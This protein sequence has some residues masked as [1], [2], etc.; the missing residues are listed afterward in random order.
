MG[1]FAQYRKRG[2]GN[3]GFIAAAPALAS[4]TFVNG[5]GHATI[6]PTNPGISGVVDVVAIVYHLA[7]PNIID[8]QFVC[9]FGSGTSGG[10]V[11]GAGV[12]MGARIAYRTAG[13][14]ITSP[15]SGEKTVTF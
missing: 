4:F 10:A 8:E 14:V 1:H 6:N 13:G 2:G 11:Y 5:A 12:Q 7:T 9:V 15:F 3:G